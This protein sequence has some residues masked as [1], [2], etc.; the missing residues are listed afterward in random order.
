MINKTTLFKNR[1]AKYQLI[2]PSPQADEK[3][4]YE[5]VYTQPQ[6]PFLLRKNTEKDTIF[7]LISKTQYLYSRNNREKFGKSYLQLINNFQPAINWAISCWDY[8][9]TIEGCRFLLRTEAQRKIH[10]GDYRAFVQRDFQR[11]VYA[12]FKKSV[13]TFKKNRLH[14]NFYHFLKTGFWDKIS[15]TYQAFENPRDRRQRKLTAYSYLRCCPYQFL[16]NYHHQLVYKNIETL[17]IEQKNII[18]SYFLNFFKY[19]ATAQKYNRSVI[20]VKQQKHAALNRLYKKD[21]L[22]CALLLQ[23][24]RY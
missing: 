10:R 5:K 21:P 13:L 12:M 17:P 9:L 7:P 3:I 14:K 24:E 11:L 6:M 18:E 16:N 2:T 19:Q 1:I 8:L 15:K 4:C 20:K 22:V 23:I